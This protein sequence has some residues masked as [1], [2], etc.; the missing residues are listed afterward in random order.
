LNLAASWTAV[1]AA[2]RAAGEKS[3]AQMI[4]MLTL[5][6]NFRSDN[7]RTS[8]GEDVRRLFAKSAASRKTCAKVAAPWAGHRLA[9]GGCAI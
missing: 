6:S 9:E 5:M 3:V 8:R 2:A 1:A 4:L 7:E